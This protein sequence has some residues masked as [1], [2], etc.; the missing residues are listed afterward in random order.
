[1]AD[2]S[3]ADIARQARSKHDAMDEIPIAAQASK[4]V[5]ITSVRYGSPVS[6]GS[7]STFFSTEGPL[8]ARARS[9][10]RPDFEASRICAHL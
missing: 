8:E 7:S 4:A 6:K 2:R 3:V 5:S 1:M 9:A 10:R